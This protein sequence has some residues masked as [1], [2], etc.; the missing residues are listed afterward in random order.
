MHNEA[1]CGD[2]AD[3][4]GDAGLER[5]RA[6][7]RKMLVADFHIE[8]AFVGVPKLSRVI[9][10]AVSTIHSYIR[11]GTFFMPHRLVNR[12]VLVSLEDLV[13]WCCAQPA[14]VAAPAPLE[15]VEEEAT[16]SAV[17]CE[18]PAAERDPAELA[19]EQA[20]RSMGI[21]PAKGRARSRRSKR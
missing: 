14:E 5:R 20:L 9:G 11:Q 19:V 17:A 7:T 4:A 21:D 1:L 8:A 10:I 12:T 3:N 2:G 18:D 13:D 15:D 6:S 16:R